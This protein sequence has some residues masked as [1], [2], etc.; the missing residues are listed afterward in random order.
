MFHKMKIAQFRKTY[1]LLANIGQEILKN[2]TVTYQEFEAI[3]QC[4]S[5]SKICGYNLMEVKKSFSN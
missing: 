5:R 1:I 2:M 3:G 4:Y